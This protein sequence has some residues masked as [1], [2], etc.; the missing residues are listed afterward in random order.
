MQREGLVQAPDG[1]GG[2]V[3]GPVVAHLVFGFHPRPS[4]FASAS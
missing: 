2:V 3:S 1:S 4:F